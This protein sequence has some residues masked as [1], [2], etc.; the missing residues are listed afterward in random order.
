MVYYNFP[1]NVLKILDCYVEEIVKTRLSGRICSLDDIR[2]Y[3]TRVPA[4]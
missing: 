4:E 2:F 1:T 3:W